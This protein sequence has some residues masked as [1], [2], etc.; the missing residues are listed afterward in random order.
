VSERLLLVKPAEQLC[1]KKE[2]LAACSIELIGC[3]MKF[4]ISCADFFSDQFCTA[5]YPALGI[6]PQ[7]SKLGVSPGLKCD[8]NMSSLYELLKNAEVCGWTAHRPVSRAGEEASSAI[9]KML[10]LDFSLA[11][12]AFEVDESKAKWSI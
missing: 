8:P 11:D 5:S 10:P 9:R 12:P 1:C 2:E 4:A 6:S 3:I 7:S